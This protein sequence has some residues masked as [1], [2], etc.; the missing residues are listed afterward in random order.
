MPFSPAT[1]GRDFSEDTPQN[2]NLIGYHLEKHFEKLQTRRHKKFGF[3]GY[4]LR[5]T[6]DKMPF[7]PATT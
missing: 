5:T 4:H 7:S 3:G 6:M 1:T 2:A